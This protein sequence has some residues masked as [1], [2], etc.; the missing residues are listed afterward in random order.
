MAPTWLAVCSQTVDAYCAALGTCQRDFATA[1]RQS[2]WCADGGLAAVTTG[3]CADGRDV[4]VLMHIDT[5][6]YFVYAGGTLVAVFT[7]LPHAM[8]SFAS[9]AGPAAYAVPTGCIQHP[10]CG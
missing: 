2:T 9:V 5:D 4:V 1:Q 3:H 8:S 10:V 7:T 6:D